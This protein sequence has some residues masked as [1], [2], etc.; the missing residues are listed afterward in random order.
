MRIVPDHVWAAL[1]IW[2]EARGE[3][4]EGQ[5][6]VA[7][8]IRNRTTQLYSSKGT[9]AST[10]LSPYQFS[11]WNTRDPNRLA[12]A[13]LDELNPAYCTAMRA[14]RE[15][16]RGSSL[17]KG[18]VLYYAPQLVDHVPEWAQPEKVIQVAEVGRHRFF[19]LKP[20]EAV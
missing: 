16:E 11:M 18:A 19:A 3:S 5:V 7:E 17:V 9:V 1:T 12:A 13:A 2:G 6:A 10:V 4:W 20:S 14:W 15:A 8:V